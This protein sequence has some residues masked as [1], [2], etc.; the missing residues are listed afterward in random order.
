MHI[1]SIN[2]EL[3]FKIFLNITEK[4]ITSK[5]HML[6]KNMYYDVVELLLTVLDFF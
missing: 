4:R 6:I 3:D 2:F 5:N 1:L